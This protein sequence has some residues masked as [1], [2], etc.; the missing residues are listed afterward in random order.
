MYSVG[1]LDKT[2]KEKQV[3]IIKNI[4]DPCKIIFSIKSK[5]Q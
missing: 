2:E 1:K 4:K 5:I 3:V